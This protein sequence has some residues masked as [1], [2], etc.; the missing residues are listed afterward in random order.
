MAVG[1]I[2]LNNMKDFLKAGIC[3]VGI[4]SCLTD[5]K[6]IEKNDWNALTELARKYVE[7]TK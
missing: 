2:D 5:K 4:G 1:G 7:A 6:M 3:S